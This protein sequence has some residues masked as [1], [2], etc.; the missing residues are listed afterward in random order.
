VDHGLLLA[1]LDRSNLSRSLSGLHREDS[2]AE[3]FVIGE[4]FQIL[5]LKI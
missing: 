4:F 2:S 3:N 1:E 5:L